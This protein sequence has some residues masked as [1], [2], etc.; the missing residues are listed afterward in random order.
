MLF[1][2]CLE[3]LAAYGDRN[4]IFQEYPFLQEEDLR[5][6]LN[7]AAAAVDDGVHDLHLIA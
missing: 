4:E 6:S 3:I 2:A 1:A 5:Q 7:Y